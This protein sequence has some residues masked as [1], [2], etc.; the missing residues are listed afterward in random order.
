MYDKNEH[1]LNILNLKKFT[2]NIKLQGAGDAFVGALA[3]LLVNFKKHPL[4]QLI[5]AACEYATL[6]VT[7]E[8]TQ[9]SYPE[10]YIPFTKQYDFITL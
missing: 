8:G 1:K 4:H 9:T 5:G 2:S 7:T 10:K 3:S 6:T